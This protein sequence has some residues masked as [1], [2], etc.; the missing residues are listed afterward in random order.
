MRGPDLSK[1][2]HNKLPPNESIATQA[3]ITMMA[4]FTLALA[5]LGM[6]M[7]CNF[8]RLRKPGYDDGT[9]IIA[10]ICSLIQLILNTLFLHHGLGR[11]VVYLT[12]H[13]IIQSY[14]F[15]QLVIFPFIFCTVITKISIA[16]MVLRLTQEQWMRYCMFALIASLVIVNGGCVVILFTYCRPYYASWDITVTGERCWSGRVLAVA[17]SVQGVWS[18]VTDLIC[19]STPLMLIW[20][21]QMSISQKIAT[22]ILIAFGLVTTGCS[23]GRCVYYATTKFSQDQTCKR[24]F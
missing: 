1:I 6:R 4:T 16:F 12:P 14:K 13:Q 7:Y 20:K 8:K 9:I 17:S 5:T 2:D 21:V 23:V 15:S 11:H 18:I 19:T 24:F 10:T 3:I 22:T